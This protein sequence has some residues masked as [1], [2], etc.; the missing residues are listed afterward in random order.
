MKQATNKNRNA[1]IVLG[2]HRSGT[3]AL[4]RTLNLCGV[5]L[6][7]NLMSPGPEDNVKG[8]WEHM[9]IYHMN[10]K[11]LL[12]L[13]SSWDDV[14]SLPD[15]W[16]NS[17]FAEAYKLEIISILE[18]DFSNSPFWG[19]KDPRICHFLP[20]WLPLL[21]QTGSKPYFLIIVRNPLEVVSSLAKRDGFSKGK[22]C[23]LWLKHLIELEK[24]TRNTS[25]MFVTYEELL[26]DWKGLL[27]R[28]EK[29]FGFKWT[30][31]PVKVSSEIKSFLQ[32]SMRHNRVTDTTLTKD[33]TLSKWIRDMYRAIN[34]IIDGDDTRLI[35]TVN[36]IEAKLKEAVSLYDPALTEIWEKYQANSA[37]LQDRSR[38]LDDINNQIEEFRQDK[39]YHLS[40]IDHLQSGIKEKDEHIQQLD[41]ELTGL[42]SELSEV[43]QT[44]VR[45]EVEVDHL[46]AAIKEKDEHIQQ[47]DTDLAGLR[48]AFGASQEA[49]KEHESKVAHL[50]VDI[51]ERDE[52]VRRLK[53]DSVGLQEQY[54]A[55]QGA[56]TEREAE[57]THL[58]TGI[59]EKN[60]HIQQID[61]ELAGLREEFAASQQS[62]K[63]HESKVANL[64]TGNKEKA[65]HIH[66]ID[67]DVGMLRDEIDS[68]R[69]LVENYR[70]DRKSIF[71]STSWKLTAPLRWMSMNARY[72]KLNLGAARY[73]FSRQYRLI[74]KSGLFDMSYY[75]DQ[76]PD[77]SESKMNPLLHYLKFGAREGRNP[78]SIF[79]TSFYL[80]QNPDVAESKMNPL[81]HYLKYG[82]KE[83]RNPSL[84]FDSSTYQI[85]NPDVS[86]SGMDPLSHYFQY[87]SKERNEHKL[88]FPDSYRVDQGSDT[89]ESAIFPHKSSN[90][91]NDRELHR[92]VQASI[93]IYVTSLNDI[94][95]AFVKSIQN[96]SQNSYCEVIVAANCNSDELIL[97]DELST[98]IKF[99][100][101]D[102]SGYFKFFNKAAKSAK[103]EF[104]VFL[105][106][107]SKVGEGW[108]EY[109]LDVMEKD[110][111][112]GLVGSKI[113]NSAGKLQDAGGIVWRNGEIYQYGL[114]DD[115]ELPEYNY[116]K[117]VDYI[118]G[119]SFIIRKELL[120]NIGG[121]DCMFSK[122]IFQYIDLAFKIRK[123]GFKVLYHPKSVVVINDKENSNSD[124]TKNININTNNSDEYKLKKKWS[125]VLNSYHLKEGSDI[126]L[127]RDRSQRKKRILVV[128]HYTPEFDMDAGS[129][130]MFKLLKIMSELDYKVI[131]W[132]ANRAYQE[133]YTW[134][135]Q[136]IGVEVLYGAIDF[137]KYLKMNGEHIEVIFLSRPHIAINFIDAAKTLTNAKIIYDTVDLVF[138]REER[139]A[140]LEGKKLGNEIKTTELLLANKADK[141]LVVSPVE[142]DILEKQGLKG[143]VSVIST[144]HSLELLNSSFE[145]RAGLM[146]IGGFMHLP[147][148]DGIVWFVQ[149]V[150]P[151]INKSLPGIHLYIVGS[152][153]TN[154]V[155]SLAS[156]NVTVTGYVKDVSFYFEKSRV[157]VSPLRYGAG[158]K[159]KIGQSM[160]YGL[161][162]VTTSIGAEG[163]GVT[164]DYNILVAD[165]ESQ[166]KE[167]VVKVYQ[168]PKLWKTLSLNARTL[169]KQKY[170]PNAIK[171]ELSKVLRDTLKPY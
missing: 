117:E 145:N 101:E 78:N 69:T 107:V 128:D 149:S 138:L 31:N 162:V 72:L 109:L 17:D 30:K 58:Q 86:E 18:R 70:I 19:V 84:T 164:D 15:R 79:L 150:F 102:G 122:D 127:T 66:Q 161:P 132:P 103:G 111:S 90:K 163:I 49:L 14:R 4:A 108:L 151:L 44:A 134:A 114:L 46:Q 26:S 59:K 136:S 81:A 165:S 56:I 39:G 52:Y 120:S 126:Y 64:E 160:A 63:E 92:H 47:L 140:K 143:K 11:L 141:V 88:L 74:K 131:F 159:G 61:T 65:E 125:N 153:P 100:F 156:P 37:M 148:E 68:L 33:K 123:R 124:R 96:E 85:Q 93:I 157:F 135:L 57:I 6:G 144:V 10:E 13:G 133:R 94:N 168:D 32:D 112:A 34:G 146:F 116:L 170:T 43:Q 155:K 21:E 139:K 97:E 22:S 41:S 89:E 71:N 67:A 55:L 3:S 38:Q 137:E 60:D 152:H 20:L 121:F 7:N 28:V 91:R 40:S 62:V 129:L 48:E 51:K 95:S 171:K 45:R 104:C 54:T 8:F 29:T 25:R 130:R 142:K 167:K 106:D 83:G 1:I 24:G 73:L 27:T 53:T 115:P 87:G 9:D 36:T 158:V 166:F 77:V 110:K 50:Q 98:G 119:N 12:D 169:I 5:D 75:L 76:N 147:N 105:H 2:M 80:K 118:S 16:W 113:L 82:W 23:L 154:K 35:K 99:V 42:R